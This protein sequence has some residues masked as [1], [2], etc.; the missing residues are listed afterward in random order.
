[1]NN[2]QHRNLAKG[3]QPLVHAVNLP[4]RPSPKQAQFHD[5]FNKE[6]KRFGLISG[7]LR[8]GKSMAAAYQAL[9]FI[10]RQKLQPPRGWIVVPVYKEGR[11][12]VDRFR[13][14]AGNLIMR[15]LRGEQSFLMVPPAGMN[16][17]YYR[18]EIRSADNPDHLRGENVAWI[19][20][21]EARDMPVEVY[22]ICHS[23]LMDTKGKMIIATTP[24]GRKHWLATDF[25]ARCGVDPQYGAV[26][27]FSTYENKT[28]SEE[29]IRTMEEE[30]GPELARQEIYGEFI[31]Q[32][33]LVLPGFN[34]S[35]HVVP[36]DGS[37]EG[38]ELYCGIDFGYS[39]HF[40]CLWV[41]HRADYYHVIGE[42]VSRY[43]TSDINAARIRESPL[44]P[45]VRIYYCDPNMLQARME[46]QKEGITLCPAPMTWKNKE[47]LSAGV[48]LLA[49]LLGEY[50]ADR[51]P[52][53]RIDPSCDTLKRQMANWRNKTGMDEP[54]DRNRDACDALRY[55]LRGREVTGEMDYSPGEKEDT[56]Y[57]ETGREESR[58][59]YWT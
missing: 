45:H 10:Y 21:D 50:A 55:C 6:G 32:G 19:W 12:A 14:A 8:S 23:R 16:V 17:P 36:W 9:Y 51:R 37:L 39:H 7:G 48:K 46:L 30:F 27:G 25:L 59:P 35:V 52:R 1:M 41:L 44:A 43:Q 11:G 33:D 24:Q 28:L 29:T 49:R 2:A 13:E 58:E 18:V 53:L 40:V 22:Q 26:V 15:E 54:S 57:N 42:Y 34:P 3:L 38:G 56:S 31:E 5:L 20:L 4:Y 47:E